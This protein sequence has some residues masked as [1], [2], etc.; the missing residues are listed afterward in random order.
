MSIEEAREALTRALEHVTEL[1]DA[2]L[3]LEGEVHAALSAL[4]AA[5]PDPLPEP[6]DPDPDPTP[7]P[8]VVLW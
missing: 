1:A 6:P 5:D 8:P 7:D 2:G 4:S 3:N